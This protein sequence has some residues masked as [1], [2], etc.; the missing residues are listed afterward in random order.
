L[1]VSDFI[2]GNWRGSGAP[3]RTVRNAAEPLFAES[4][5]L[6]ADGPVR[7]MVAGRMDHSKGHH[8]ALEATVRLRSQGRDIRLD[9]FGGPTQGNAYADDL[10]AR[11]AASGHAEA[12]RIM[13]FC[14]DLRR[15]HQEYHLGLQC[16]IDPE[17][18]SCWVCE[19][20]VD[21]LPLVASRNGGT[22]ELVADE[23]TGLL[24]TSG[25]ANDL[26]E[27]IAVLATDRPRLAAMRLAAFERG[28]SH[29][30]PGRMM[31]ETFEA[32][33]GMF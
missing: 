28:Q 33:E 24:F 19:T 8:L 12:I 11:I 26:A 5:P 14:A 22:P 17:P 29:F 9:I 23:V 18:C 16:R 10:G 6:P 4:L 7:C 32:Y 3:M 13:G 20:L 2:A 30:L 15:R 25:D 21:G 31:R 27:K 1:P